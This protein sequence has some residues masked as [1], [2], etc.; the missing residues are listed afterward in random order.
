MK[1]KL[2][3]ADLKKAF[4]KYAA[5]L[6]YAGLV[7]IFTVIKPQYFTL[8]NFKSILIQTAMLGIIANGMTL[9]MMTGGADLS[10]GAIAGVCTLAGIWP[11][12]FDKLPLGSG[13][14]IALALGIAFGL[15]NGVCV[16]RLGVAPFV[17]TLGSMFLAQGLQYLFSDGGMS[18][19]Y[20]F[21][22]AYK[23]LGSGS[24]GPIPMPIVIYALL[25]TALLLLT[26]YA[27]MGRYLRGTGL[28]QFT[29]EL[30]GIRIRFYTLLSYVL[31][32]LFA[33][34]LGLV[35]GASQSYVSPD[36]GN[37][38][39]MDSLMVVLLGKTLMNNKISI[40]A[41]A[42]GALL[43]RSFE[44]GLAMV[45]IPVTVLNVCKGSL[46]VAILLLTLISKRKRART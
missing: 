14:L 21:P 32:G 15:L 10:V 7:L 42:Y 17:A 11:V 16:A 1:E 34:I 31:C 8:M 45:G 19:S 25:F 28:N 9:V 40:Y 39:L 41:T 2:K 22:E 23:F 26:E 6:V 3:G 35:L 33:A 27:P 18:I 36:H 44:T 29:S 24:L 13:I 43:L 30:S 46:L 38:F 37:S 20:G 5:L 12:V 4:K